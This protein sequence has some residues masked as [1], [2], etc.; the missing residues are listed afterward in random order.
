VRVAVTG[1]SGLIGRALVEQLRA[2]GDEPVLLVRRPP[3]GAEERQWD[4][5]ADRLDPAVLDEVDAI[6]HLAGAGIG[7]QR[8]TASRRR[9]IRDSRVR[10]TAL[11]AASIAA[12]ERPPAT[13]VSGSAIGIYG[14]CGDLELDETSPPGTG[15]LAGVCVDWERA[16]EPAAAAGA[17]VVLARTGVVL[18]AG[19]G[20]LARQLPLFRAGLGGPLGSGRQWVSWIAL[21]DEVGALCH[22]LDSDLTGPVNVTAPSPVTNA[23]LTRVLA[24]L[25]HRPALLRAPRMALDLT[26]GRELVQEVLLASQRV[27][28]RRLL[29]SGFTFRYPD[30]AGA[31]AAVIG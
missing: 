25:V 5:M 17:R 15:F 1:A 23:E 11:L 27:L 28:P 9:E 13:F 6:V 26:L 2:R 31:L 10:G 12:A 4:P 7:D 8:W 16:T 24:S 21:A 14:D 30:L 19:G 29:E 22:M 3:R 20:A 18:G